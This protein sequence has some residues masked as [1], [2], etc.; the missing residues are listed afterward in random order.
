MVDNVKQ[1]KDERPV[2]RDEI[3]TNLVNWQRSARLTQVAGLTGVPI[4]SLMTYVNE[5]RTTAMPKDHFRA[6]A[7]L[8]RDGGL[9]PV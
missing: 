2:E 4:S 1:P 8:I 7:R 9:P 3:Y 6:L 5:P